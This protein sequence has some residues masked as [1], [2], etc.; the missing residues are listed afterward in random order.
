MGSDLI[1]P[2]VPPP[3]TS[4]LTSTTANDTVARSLIPCL[5][6]FIIL[7][8]TL[9]F[10]MF[11]FRP[12]ILHHNVADEAGQPLICASL[13]HASLVE[14]PAYRALSYCWGDS[15]IT[16]TIILDGQKVQVTTNLEA[17]LK[18]LKARNYE[19]LWIDALCS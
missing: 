3:R 5:K 9:D 10:V 12:L 16:Q 19:T 14:P 6:F 13:Q 15:H 4:I 2:T 18:V 17:A 7:Y 1:D 8:R 11:E